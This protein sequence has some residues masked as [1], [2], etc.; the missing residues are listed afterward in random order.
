M[1]VTQDCKLEI[2]INRG[3]VDYESL[4]ENSKLQK[5]KTHLSAAQKM[6]DLRSIN[7]GQAG[8]IYVGHYYSCWHP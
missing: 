4:F 7:R 8:Q 1:I 3:R 5:S 2:V 6:D